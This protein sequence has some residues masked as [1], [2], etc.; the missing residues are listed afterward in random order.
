MFSIEKRQH[1]ISVAKFVNFRFSD[2]KS[3]EHEYKQERW[4]LIGGILLMPNSIN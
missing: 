2:R 4:L 1:V 3:G